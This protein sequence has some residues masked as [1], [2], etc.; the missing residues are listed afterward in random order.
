MA[1]TLTSLDTK[2]LRQAARETPEE[3]PEFQIAPMIDV[4]LVLLVFFMSIS[5][6]Q[7]MQITG[8]VAL[9]V[10]VDGRP[11]ED[12]YSGVI[13]VTYLPASG[14]SDITMNERSY[15]V[16]EDLGPELQRAAEV[17]GAGYKV[18]IRADKNTKYSFLRR[19]LATAGHAGIGNVTFAVT[20]KEAAP[21]LPASS[22]H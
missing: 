21:A 20:D 2:K 11:M 9:P 16:P 8:N 6:T 3:D 15:A 19:I 22:T 1:H 10:A 14:T 13:N 5:S 7:V 12:L 17:G 4:L 18:V